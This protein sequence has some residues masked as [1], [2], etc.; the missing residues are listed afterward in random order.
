MQLETLRALF[1]LTVAYGWSHG[2]DDVV[3]AFLHGDLDETIYMRQPEGYNDGT[4]RVA[5]LL[6]SI[7]GLKQTARIWNK[8]MHQK[9]ITVGY[10]QLTSDTAI[11]LHNHND[12]ITILA[13]YI[14]NVMSFRNTKP[15]LSKSRA[16][17]HKLFEMKEE[18][19]NW[20][21]GIKLIKNHKEATVSIDHSLYVNAVLRRFGMDDCNT[22][23]TPLDSGNVLSVHDCPQTDEERSEMHTVPYWELIG[24]L[25]W[26]AVVL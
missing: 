24:T 16:E 23:R 10:G 7:Y 17:L 13:I 15:G 18:D 11:Y 21:M 3:A 22:T 1:H 4:G 12:D 8:L 19:P 25:T 20:V 6:H 9:L 5:R 14:D 26:I 2:Q